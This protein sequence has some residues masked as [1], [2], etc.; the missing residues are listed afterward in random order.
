MAII[1]AA[2]PDDLSAI[3]DYLARRFAGAGGAARYRRYF[4]YAWM[5]DRPNL[6]FLIE[7]GGEIRGF[8]GAIYGRRTIRGTSHAFCNISS[9]SV[10]DDHRKLSLHMLKRLL[11]QKGYTFTCFSPSER[12]TEVLAFFKFQTIDR[13]KILFSPLSGLLGLPQRLRRPWPRVLTRA[14]GMERHLDAEQRRIF[15]DHA[16]YRLGQFLLRHGDERCYFV[17]GRR[18]RGVKVFA[19]LLHASN[20]RLLV[21]QIGA[22]QLPLLREHR[23]LLFGI[24]R[25]FV[26]EPPPATYRYARL[27]APMFRSESLAAAEIDSL[28]TEMAPMLG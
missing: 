1:R 14:D 15:A 7:D 8:L 13:E 18:G 22:A 10:D 9:W 11:D 19:D 28:Y 2:S 6:G 17:T 16:P 27:R 26:G 20:P 24:D 25:R 3:A 21:E 4:D 5:P 12:V 23:T